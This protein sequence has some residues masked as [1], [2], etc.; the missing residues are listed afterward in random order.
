MLKTLL[1]LTTFFGMNLVGFTAQAEREYRPGMTCHLFDPQASVS[2]DNP[3]GG[4]I[5]WEGE[6]GHDLKTF[7]Y[8]FIRIDQNT[9]EVRAWRPGQNVND[10]VQV[11][12]HQNL[13]KRLPNTGLDLNCE[14]YVIQG[15]PDKI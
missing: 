8:I 6:D 10:V 3:E 11:N 15:P 4:F 2:N 7:S 5:L 13:E 12:L 14:A 9:A 1:T